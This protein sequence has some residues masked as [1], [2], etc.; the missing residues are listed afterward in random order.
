LTKP[1][2]RA[3]RPFRPDFLSPPGQTLEEIL[4]ERALSQTELARRLGVS[5]KHVNQIINGAATISAEIAL[6]LE[7]VL[8][9]SAG[10]WLNRDALFQAEL[11]RRQQQHDLVAD[12]GWAERFPI[13][14]LKK[15]GFL[16]RKVTGTD[17]VAELLGFLGVAS[18]RQWADPSPAYRKSLKFESDPYALSA[19]LRVGEIEG[20]QQ[21]C[22]PFDAD[23]F[24]DALQQIRSLTCKTPSEWEPALKD[25]CAASGVIV[26]VVDTFAQARVNGA[27]RWLSPHRAIIQLSLRYRWED[28]FWFTFFHEACHLLNHRKK[29]LFIEPKKRPGATTPELQEW[30]RLEEE[31]DRF[32]TRTLIPSSHDKELQSLSITDVPHFAQELGIAPAIVIG[33]MQHD[34]LIPYSHGNQLRRRLAFSD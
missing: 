20:Q 24:M 1:N 4:D 32:A 31:A 12:L 26:V 2:T 27:A 25:V 14:E 9:V 22:A 5:L 21:R 28:I 18:P 33:R 17:L 6:G 7:K 19:W 15:R 34:G 23:L 11:A 10:F 13:D 8:G 16:P 29:Q 3:A 30:L